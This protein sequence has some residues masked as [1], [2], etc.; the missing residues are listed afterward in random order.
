MLNHIDL[1]GRLVRDP[2]LRKTQSGV[3]VCNFTLA[4]DRDYTNGDEKVA[5]FI[6]CV[7]WRNTADFVSK[8]LQKGRMAIVSGSLHMRKWTDNNGNNRTAAEIEADH[9]YFGDSKKDGCGN[10]GNAF[11]SAGQSGSDFAEVEGPD[12]ELPF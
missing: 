12:S 1:M 10:N 4:C 5:D 3:S 9:V 8:Y 11:A 6:D 7:A 2:E